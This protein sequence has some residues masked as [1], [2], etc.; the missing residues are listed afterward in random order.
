[1]LGLGVLVLMLA[2][3][4]AFLVLPGVLTFA[5]TDIGMLIAVLVRFPHAAFARRKEGQAGNLPQLDDL[6]IAG[7]RLERLDQEGLH[8]LADPE[9]HLGLLERALPMDAGCSCAPSRSP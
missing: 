4:L 9:H 2:R 8:R 5:V 7:K 1:M 6:G 3:V